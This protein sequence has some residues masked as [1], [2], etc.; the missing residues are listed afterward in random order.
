MA[1][2]ELKHLFK[3]YVPGIHS[4]TDVNMVIDNEDFIVLVGPSGCVVNLQL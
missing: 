3:D 4:V 2:I 1:K